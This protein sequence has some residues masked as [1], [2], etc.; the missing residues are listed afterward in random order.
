[1]QLVIE[2]IEATPVWY[3]TIKRGVDT[4]KGCVMC[5]IIPDNLMRLCKELKQQQ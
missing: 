1:M 2:F 3:N 4:S 5:G